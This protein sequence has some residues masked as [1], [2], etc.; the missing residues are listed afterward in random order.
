MQDRSVI[1]SVQSGG[2]ISEGAQHPIADTT[3]PKPPSEREPLI[4]RYAKTD[5]DVIAIHRFLCVVMGPQLPGVIEHRDSAN[6]IWRVVNHDIA[7]MAIRGGMLVGTLGVVNPRFWWNSKIG[8]LA[9][10]WL[11]V[12]PASQCLRPLLREGIAVAKQSDLELHIYDERRGRLIIFNK[13][14]RRG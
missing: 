8:F 6:E 14:K 3:L 11:G 10:R 4:I 9:N 12:L 5:D 7:W 1:C 2:I 13:S